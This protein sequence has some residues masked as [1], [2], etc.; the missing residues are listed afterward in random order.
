MF[1]QSFLHFLYLGHICTLSN[2]ICSNWQV[3]LILLGW[4]GQHIFHAWERWML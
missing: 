4:H 3:Y 1:M 2:N